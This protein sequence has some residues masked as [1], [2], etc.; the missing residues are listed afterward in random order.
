MLSL[1]WEEHHL[2]DRIEELVADLHQLHGSCGGDE[3][4]SALDGDLDVFKAHVADFG[5][6]GVDD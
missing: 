4:A 5:G 3:G 2:E 1:P 6:L